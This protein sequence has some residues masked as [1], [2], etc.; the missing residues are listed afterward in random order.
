M[1]RVGEDALAPSS[2]ANGVFCR[3][4]GREGNSREPRWF[5]DAPRE[6]GLPGTSREPR[7]GDIWRDDGRAPAPGDIWRDD[8]RP[9]SGVPPRAPA[10]ADGVAAREPPGAPGVAALEPGREPPSGVDT[11]EVPERVEFAG[12]DL[13]ASLFFSAPRG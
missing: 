4:V 1:G 6:L 3:D 2:S 5:G 8:G 9:P 12:D 10:A 7:A 13:R 11:R